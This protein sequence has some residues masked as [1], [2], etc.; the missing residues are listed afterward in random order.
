M[1]LKGQDVTHAVPCGLTPEMESLLVV[2]MLP[3]AEAEYNVDPGR[4]VRVICM[5]G[6]LFGERDK[7]GAPF[8]VVLSAACT[9][10]RI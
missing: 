8:P 5:G 2:K 4:F 10:L 3:C 1:H 7:Y 6:A 9:D